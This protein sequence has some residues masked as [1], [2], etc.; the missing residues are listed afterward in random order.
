MKGALERL[1]F[2]RAAGYVLLHCVL[3]TKVFMQKKTEE[4]R[5]EEREGEGERDR[6]RCYVFCVVD[7]G[8]HSPKFIG[9]LGGISYFRFAE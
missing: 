8:L 3:R 2:S 7:W 4:K 1:P 6:E 5:G 9:S